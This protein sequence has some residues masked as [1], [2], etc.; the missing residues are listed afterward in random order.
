[1]CL[2]GD[3]SHS[4]KGIS[5]SVLNAVKEIPIRMISYGGSKYNMSLLV[6]TKDKVMALKLLND[7]LFTQ[8]R[9]KAV[10]A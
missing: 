3:F 8:K 4:G 5:A 10:K 2:A 1:I 6:D 9:I 7:G